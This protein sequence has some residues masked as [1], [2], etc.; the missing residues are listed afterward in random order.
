[1]P[2]GEVKTK[3]ETADTAGLVRWLDEE[4]RR[5]KTLLLELKATVDEQARQILH[6]QGLV[7][8]LREQLDQTNAEVKGLSKFDQALQRLRD[9]LLSLLKGTEQSVAAQVEGR[10]AGLVEERQARMGAVAALERR[11]DQALKLGQQLDTQKVDIERL[12]KTAVGLQSQIDAAVK[13]MKG[14]QER[15]LGLSEG[16]R[17]S[18]EAVAR[19]FQDAEAGKTRSASIEESIKLLRVQL[20]QDGQ[21]IAGLSSSDET[22][23]QQQAELASELRRVDDRG[24]KEISGWTKEMANW[25]EDARRLSEQIAQADKQRREAQRVLAS[26]D[27]LKIQLEKDRDAL[28]HTERTAEERQRQQLEEWRKENELLWLTNEEKWQQ[29]AQENERRDGHVAL[30]WETQLSYFRREVSQLGK[31]IKELEKRLLRSKT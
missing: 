6:S 21:Q 18:E 17:R 10:D 26:L 30:L 5:D 14:Q 23:S 16:V 25:R 24:K 13:E 15:L 29:L 9:E 28:V 1:M 8:S 4:R 20:E 22:L 7:E 12:S 19:F 27:A 31:F 3:Q 11:I 2:E